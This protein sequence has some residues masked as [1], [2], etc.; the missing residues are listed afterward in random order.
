MNIP[1][2]PSS[3]QTRKGLHSLLFLILVS[4]LTSCSALSLT[5]HYADWLMYWR[6][7]HY[8]DLSSYQK[9]VLQ[10]HL[11]QLHSCHREPDIPRYV[12]FLQTIHRHWQDGFTQQELD[13]I[14]DQ[15]AVL[16]GRLGSHVASESVEFLTTVNPEQVQH[17]EE[18]M[19]ADNQELLIEFGE[20]PETRKANRV[21]RVLNWFRTWL[22]E[23]PPSQ[24]QGF[25]KVIEQYP[26]TTDQWL[27]YR[28][29]RQ[30]Q[31]ASL[32]RSGADAQTIEK[33]VHDWL[34]TPGEDAPYSYADVARNRK[35]HLKKSILAIDG[36]VTRDQRQHASDR[37]QNLIEEVHQMSRP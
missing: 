7:D 2:S 35:R 6:I 22:G 37:L 17:L 19:E 5:Y 11:T 21:E 28:R 29:Y 33:Q 15:Y 25:T 3:K 23:I 27:E 14:F 18:V 31:F 12:S 9:P 26:D 1:F 24:Q 36:M 34:V 13:E 30:H 10:T 16:R 4:L 32:L 20:N 8:F